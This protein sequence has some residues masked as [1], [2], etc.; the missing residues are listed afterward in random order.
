VLVVAAL[1]LST[2]IRTPGNLGVYE[3]T[4]LLIYSSL[5]VPPALGLAAAVLQHF[6]A[7][8]PRLGGGLIVLAARGSR[9]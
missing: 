2:L 9:V 3:A 4:V 7:L 5:G 8:V 1:G 6:A